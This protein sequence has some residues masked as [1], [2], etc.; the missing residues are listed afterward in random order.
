M[1]YIMLIY[2]GT[3]LEQCLARGRPMLR[4]SQGVGAP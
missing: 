4:G 3:A 1:K 2:Q